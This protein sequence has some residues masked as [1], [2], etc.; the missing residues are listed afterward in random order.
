ML[1][2]SVYGQAIIVTVYCRSSRCAASRGRCSTDGADGDLRARRGVRAL[3]DVR[4]RDGRARDQRRVEETGERCSSA[5]RSAST[6]RSSLGARAARPVVGVAV[7]LFAGALLSSALGQE[8]VPTLDEKDFALH[9]IRIPSTSLTQST[10]MQATLERASRASPRWRFVFSKTGTA[11]MAS[12]PMPPNVSDTFVILKPRRSGR[13]PARPRR[14][15]RAARDGVRALPGNNYEFTQPIQMR[16]NELIAGVRSDV[17][18]KVY[19]D[20]FDAM[21]DAATRSR[22]CC[23]RSAARPT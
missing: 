17:A 5:R 11:E 14:A 12:D 1:Q 20:D 23:A 4:A 8:F 21:R 15:R 3:A 6:R 10:A 16:F 18:V 2:P 7:A 13:I 22:A 9:A 19:G